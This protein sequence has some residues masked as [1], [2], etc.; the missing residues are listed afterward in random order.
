MSIPDKNARKEPPKAARGQ[1]SASSVISVADNDPDGTLGGTLFKVDF[2]GHLV[3]S[4]GCQDPDREASIAAALA[5]VEK[6]IRSDMAYVDG[7]LIHG[8]DDGNEPPKPKSPGP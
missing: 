5:A 7:T 8:N 3:F 1:T 6:R 2:K 4:Y